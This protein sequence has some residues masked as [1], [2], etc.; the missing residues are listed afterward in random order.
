MLT[1]AVSTGL[2]VLAAGAL[3][4]GLL[5]GAS[6]GTSPAPNG[7]GARGTVPVSPR[8]C[9]KAVA[10]GEPRALQSE[11]PTPRPVTESCGNATMRLDYALFSALFKEAPGTTLKDESGQTPFF[12]KAND[13][14]L[15]YVMGGVINGP[16]GSGG[17]SVTVE[18]YVDLPGSG[19]EATPSCVDQPD[20]TCVARTEPDGTRVRGI[21]I[22]NQRA[23]GPIVGKQYQIGVV[24]T[25]GTL[26]S[27]VATNTYY[28]DKPA[29]DAT[30]KAGAP[31]PLLSVDQMVAIARTP[32]MTLYP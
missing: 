3:T 29:P 22:H 26:V 32:A 18:P 31:E 16:T 5:N 6:T 1:V 12:V 28:E 17:L 14:N 2:T 24:R 9:P 8:V 11:G 13:E 20:M 25:D 10:T 27:F 21:L 7:A 30:P 19:G 4:V 23:S 15:S